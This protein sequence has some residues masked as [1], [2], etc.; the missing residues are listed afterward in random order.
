MHLLLSND[1][2]ILA[3]GLAALVRALKGHHALTVLAPEK[4]RSSIG[5][6]VTLHKPLRIRKMGELEGV[7]MFAANGSPADCVLLGIRRLAEKPVD[8]VISGIN[9]GQNMGEDLYYSG[10]V[11][12]AR[13]AV[14]NGVP[15][16][17]VS[18]SGRKGEHF[19]TAGAVAL[20]LLEHP[21]FG[22]EGHTLWNVNVPDA[23][24]EVLLPVRWTRPGSRRY[25]DMIESRSDPRGRPY[26]WIGGAL[27]VTDDSE[28]T[29]YHAVQN[30]AP[31]LSP[32]LVPPAVSDW[33]LPG[34]NVE[35]DGDA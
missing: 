27:A 9:L 4:E 18:L 20:R 17:A 1:D 2:G 30:N 32:L 34:H 26:H 35:W 8:A 6:S 7:G 15:A 5:H 24:L 16:M 33:N 31:S 22:Y 10:T 12:A 28:G 21:W 14:L 3:P 23:P 13:E 19:D 25:K 29:D 11:A